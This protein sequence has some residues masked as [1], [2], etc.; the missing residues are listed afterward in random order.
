MGTG[1]M[2]QVA[3]SFHVA[4]ARIL[5]LAVIPLTAALTAVTNASSRVLWGFVSDKIGREYTMTLAF[6][7]EAVFVFLVTQVSD[8]P[9]L[10]VVAFSLV[11]LCWGEIYALFPAVSGDVFGAK[12]AASNYGMMYTAKGVAS[13]LGGYGA[14]LVAAKVEFTGVVRCSVLCG[15]MPQ[16]ACRCSYLL[17]YRALVSSRI[18]GKPKRGSRSPRAEIFS[19]IMFE[20]AGAC[21]GC[22][23]QHWGGA[24]FCPAP[25]KIPLN[26][27]H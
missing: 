1:N 25:H 20:G 5:G 12:Y 9:V 2:A 22:A 8:N 4:D 15:S 10:F 7:L 19:R 26:Y 21:P 6:T 3:K 27:R 11:F 16:R 18:A 23:I 14:A 24:F 13:I 17:C